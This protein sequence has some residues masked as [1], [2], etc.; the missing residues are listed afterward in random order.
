MGAGRSHR[1][2]KSGWNGAGASAPAITRKI[3]RPAGSFRGNELFRMSE[4]LFRGAA[5]VVLP[6]R[7]TTK[8]EAARTH[9]KSLFPIK[10]IEESDLGATPLMHRSKTGFNGKNDHLG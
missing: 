5:R 8:I 6:R 2:R 4:L 1:A 9:I 3:P 7:T 10:H